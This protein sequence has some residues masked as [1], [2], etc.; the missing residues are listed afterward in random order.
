MKWLW[1]NRI[2]LWLEEKERDE[3]EYIIDEMNLIKF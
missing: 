1:K 2:G 3:I